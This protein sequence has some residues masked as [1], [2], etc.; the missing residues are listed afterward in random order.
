MKLRREVSARSTGSNYWLA[1]LPE[2]SGSLLNSNSTEMATYTITER[3]IAVKSSAVS[4]LGK[5]ILAVLDQGLI[6]GSNFVMGILLARWLSEEQYG[7]YALAFSI[8]L[9]LSQFYTSLLLE[10]MAVFGGSIYRSRLR[11][12]LGTLLWMHL[13]TALAIFLVLGTAASVAR[14]LHATANLPSALA[15][16]TVASPC[17]LLFWLMRR[18]FYLELS[19]SAAVMSAVFYCV[20]VMGGLFLLYHRG[21]LSAFTAF[22]LMAFGALMTSA[23]S[24]VRLKPFFRLKKLMPSLGESWGEHWNYGR[25][26]LAT[27]ALLW[28]P[29]NFYYPVVSASAGMAGAGELKAL[30]NLALPIG[31]T[32][33]ALSLLFQPYASRVNHQHGS[34]TLRKFTGKISLLYAGGGFAYWFL[35][36]IFRAPIVHFL[37]GGHYQNLVSLVPWLALASVLQISLAGPAIGLRALE[38]P[39]SVFVAYAASGAI[40]VLGG[41]PLTWAMGVQGVIISM[42]LSSVVGFSVALY[43]LSR[44]ANSL[45]AAAAQ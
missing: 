15:A 12:Y 2:L 5:V 26:S 40:A 36:V 18:A 8:F 27:A 16:V 29:S 25:W 11:G 39:A 9:L 7:A 1:S 6:S 22:L 45:S 3:L 32:A 41:I 10:P 30:L 19:P 28:L 20:I 31:H 17:I 37:Y 42:M 43:L 33:T 23:F 35:I 14:A 34:G 21:Y 4:W 24:M 44:K 38:S 13:G